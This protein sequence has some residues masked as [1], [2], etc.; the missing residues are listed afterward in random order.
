MFYWAINYDLRSRNLKDTAAAFV[1]SRDER[2]RH[3]INIGQTT[4]RYN[5]IPTVTHYRRNIQMYKYCQKYCIVLD[6]TVILII[7]QIKIGVFEDVD[8]NTKL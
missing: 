4:L 2:N 8:K 5:Y 6:N 3:L 7:V 1:V